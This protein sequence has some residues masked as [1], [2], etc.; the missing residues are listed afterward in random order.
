MAEA[1]ADSLKMGMDNECAELFHQGGQQFRLRKIFGRGEAGLASE[2]DIDVALKRLFTARFRLGLFR[3]P[4]QSSLS[5]TPDSEIDSE[6]HRELALKMARESIVLL[7]NNGV[8]PLGADVK[9]IA[10]VG[11]SRPVCPSI[12]G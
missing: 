9:K 7:K 4:R 6:A 8:L 1:G 3:S 11:P 10:V 2:G 5:Q 12:G